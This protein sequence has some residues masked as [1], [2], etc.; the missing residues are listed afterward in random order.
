MAGHPSRHMNQPGL[1]VRS[2]APQEASLSPPE[3][4]CSSHNN[5]AANTQ[6]RIRCRFRVTTSM[7]ITT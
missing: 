3:C 7:L 5:N 2:C 1:P 4:M 6:R